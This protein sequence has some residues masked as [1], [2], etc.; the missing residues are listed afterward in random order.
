MK[1]KSRVDGKGNSNDSTIDSV[2][3]NLFPGTS[4]ANPKRSRI[5]LIIDD[6]QSRI[7]S[8]KQ[9]FQSNFYRKRSASNSITTSDCSVES[10]RN[11]QRSNIL[12]HSPVEAQSN[13]KGTNKSCF[14]IKG[15]KLLRKK[16]RPKMYREMGQK[17]TS[18]CSLKS[19]KA[20]VIP[21]SQHPRNTQNQGDYKDSGYLK[22][23][24]NLMRKPYSGLPKRKRKT[25]SKKSK[26]PKKEPQKVAKEVKEA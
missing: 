25:W 23:N 16:S 6:Y 13:Y 26:K 24:Q 18:L 10:Y 14:N 22:E 11:H 7:P 1:Y 21:I 17:F 12:N 20:A 15:N 5:K 4:Q 3:K 2:K 9:P 8:L 19:K